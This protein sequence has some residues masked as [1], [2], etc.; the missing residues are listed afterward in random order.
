MRSASELLSMI[1][2]LTSARAAFAC[3][4]CPTARAVRGLVFADHPWS[5]LAVTAAPF[6]VFA[7]V[8]W[9]LS[10]VGGSP[11]NPG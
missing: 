9:A 6:V 4:N 10:R 7:A 5:N 2:V 11:R 1:G 3:P 8:V